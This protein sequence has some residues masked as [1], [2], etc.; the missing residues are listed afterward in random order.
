MR[1]FKHTIKCPDIIHGLKEFKKHLK[2]RKAILLWDGLPAHRAGDTVD[3][4]NSQK[5]WLEIK[6]FPAYA[7]ELN[8]PEYLWSVGKNKDLAHLYVD[9]IDNLDIHIRRYKQRVQRRTDI[10]TGFLKESGLFKKELSS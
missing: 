6:R 1:I 7:P 10:L 5:R 4:I 9:N 3:Y 2:G 8:P